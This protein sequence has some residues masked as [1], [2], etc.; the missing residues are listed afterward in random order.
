MEKKDSEFR[1]AEIINSCRELYKTNSFKDIT[2]KLISEKTSFSRPSIYNYFE[3]KEEI[4]LAILKE[5]YDK[6]CIDLEEIYNKNEKLTKTEFAEQL[7]KSIEKRKTL[8][9]LLSMNLY[10]IEDNSR[11]DRLIDFKSSYA[12]SI[13]GLKKLLAKFFVDMKD[14][15]INGFMFSFLPLMYGIYPYAIVDPKQKEAMEK[16][17]VPFLYNSIYDTAYLGIIKILGE[18]K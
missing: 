8:L 15:D 10:D 9:K 3:T 17:N 5:E 13:N 16:A 7:A 4:F 12:N 6:W 14:N 18:D 1:R 11:M 2:I